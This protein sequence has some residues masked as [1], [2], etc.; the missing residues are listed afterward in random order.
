MRY[1]SAQ[2]VPAF[3]VDGR[4]GTFAW[5]FNHFTALEAELGGHYNG[6]INNHEFDTTTFSYLFGPKGSIHL[7]GPV[8]PYFHALFG[9]PPARL[10]G[11]PV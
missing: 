6:H 10:S 1:N 2:T 8:V 11:H 7:G 9:G 5:N 4:I 3:T